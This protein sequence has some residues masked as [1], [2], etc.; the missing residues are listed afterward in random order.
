M[1]RKAVEPNLGY[2]D[3]Y[4]EKIIK[5]AEDHW[6]ESQKKP[7]V[8]ISLPIYVFPLQVL[9]CVTKKDRKFDVYSIGS[10]LKFSVFGWI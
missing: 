6:K 8:K 7:E 4:I 2:M 9:H 1:N 3:K 5:E 10:Q